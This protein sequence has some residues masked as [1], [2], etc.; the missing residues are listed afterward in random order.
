MAFLNQVREEL[1]E[2]GNHQ[3]ADVHTIDIGIGRHNDLVVSQAFHTVLDV[4]GRLEKIEFF[5]FID[6]LLGEAVGVERLTTE[7]EHGLCVHI[8]ALG[9]GTA[10]RIALGDKNT[11]FF[12][13]VTLGIVQ[14]ETAI[15][16]LP[17]VEIRFLGTFTGQLG[18]TGN[19]LAFL[20]RF[21]NLLK[22]HI[23]HLRILV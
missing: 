8:A 21:L 16:K 7:A 4:E 1:E 17:V 23:G 5:V 10:R 2:E 9:D 18:D 11:S 3:Q 12:L 22:H 6:H 13:L 19:G 14:V 15:T 20:L